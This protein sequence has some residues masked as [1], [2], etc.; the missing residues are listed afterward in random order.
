VQLAAGDRR[1]VDAEECFCSTVQSPMA[2]AGRWKVAC[3]AWE[4]GQLAAACVVAAVAVAALVVALLV[5]A[6]V[7]VAAA[8]IVASCYS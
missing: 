5:V 7:A 1:D 2:G 6:A 4:A 8:A 3:D